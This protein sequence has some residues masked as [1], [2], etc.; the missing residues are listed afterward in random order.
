MIAC[1]I[2]MN[3]C[4][5]HGALRGLESTLKSVMLNGRPDDYD[6]KHDVCN[7][8]EEYINGGG[9]RYDMNLDKGFYVC[10]HCIEKHCACK[11]LLDMLVEK[12]ADKSFKAWN[13][14]F[15][16]YEY[17]SVVRSMATQF[18]KHRVAPPFPHRRWSQVLEDVLG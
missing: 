16:D 1:N 11:D 6:L 5:V 3:K 17:M 2:C 4:A 14:P 15:D 9:F 10:R 18:A 7:A 8:V 13:D 12:I